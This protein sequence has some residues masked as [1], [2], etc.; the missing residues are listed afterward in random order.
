MSVEG[1]PV[2]VKQA[3]VTLPQPDEFGNYWL[4][5]HQHDP[6][7]FPSKRRLRGGEVMQVAAT[8]YATLGKG[9]GFLMDGL[10]V[11]V[12]PTPAEALAALVRAGW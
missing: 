3:P 11:R 7:I 6:A 9:R 12:F 10:R 5:H 8:Y 2:K 4:G 1:E